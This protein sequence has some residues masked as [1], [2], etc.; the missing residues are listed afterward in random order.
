MKATIKKHY[1]W[2]IVAAVL[3]ELFVYGGIAN[4]LN[5]LFVIPVTEDLQIS[6][7]SFSLPWLLK[8]IMSFTGALLSGMVLRRFG[9]RKCV[10]TLLITG[11]VGL[12]LLA[13]SKNVAM[14]CLGAG[15]FGLSDGACLT[16]G[17]SR[18]VNSWFY[19]HRGTVLGCVTAATGLGGSVICIVLTGIMEKNGWQ[20]AYLFDGML[21]LAMSVLIWILVKD[22]PEKM[23]LKPYGEG[24]SD[25]KQKKTRN[26]QWEGYDLKDLYR[27]PFFYL[28]LAGTAL[29]CFLVYMPFSTA[30]AH[31]QDCGL[32]VQQATSMQSVMLL[33]LAADKL[34]MGIL[35]DKIGAK[36]VTI[37]CF[38]CGIISLVCMA[39]ANGVV[40]SAIAMFLL[41][42][43][44]P[45]T[46]LTVPLLATELLGY[47]GQTTSI[48]ISVAMVQVGSMLH[49]PVI[50]S[51]FDAFGSYRPAYWAAAIGLVFVILMYLLTYWLAD[52]DKKKTFAEQT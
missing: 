24:E 44:L 26:T 46:G 52:R 2:I 3:L 31:L 42:A 33:A 28:L 5:S 14:L 49:G 25:S 32:T 6:R 40:I 11:A 15:I 10:G 41:A 34:L 50:Q 43:A 36:W 22:R 39:M 12:L 4:N 51:T 29:S 47:K 20:A 48:G 23:G 18:I 19:R 21:L 27:K 16:A 35:S 8:S 7:T 37:L 1:H 30:V 38:V 45:I 9:Y 13:S 17:P